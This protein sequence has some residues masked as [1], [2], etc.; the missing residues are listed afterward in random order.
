MI[1]AAETPLAESAKRVLHEIVRSAATNRAIPAASGNSDQG[2]SRRVD[3][4]LT[5][6]YV[7]QAARV[8]STLPEGVAAQAFLLAIGVG[9][10]DAEL[11]A[12]VPGAGALAQAVEAPSERTIRTAVL[13]EPTLHG[14]RDLAQHFFVS[15]Y[16]TAALSAEAADAAGLAKE[17]LDA[18]GGSGLSFADLAVDRAGVRFADGILNKRVPLSLLPQTFSVAVFVP[19][20]DG[21]PEGLTAGTLRKQYGARNDPRFRKQLAEIDARIMALPPYRAPILRFSQ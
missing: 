20:L 7:R 1:S 17:M 14:R 2:P 13:G 5:E 18:Q 21:L 8:A 10:G 16:L 3:D 12:R 6:Y 15:V 11:L 9:L 19:N 4:A